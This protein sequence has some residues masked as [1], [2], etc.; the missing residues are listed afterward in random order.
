MLRKKV[1]AS[2][3]QSLK[4]IYIVG[5]SHMAAIM[6]GLKDLTT[7]GLSVYNVHIWRLFLLSWF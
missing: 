4:K 6:Y 2:L 3:I 7:K 1:V 5:D